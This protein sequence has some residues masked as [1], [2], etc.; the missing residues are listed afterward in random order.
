MIAFLDKLF[1]GFFVVIGLCLVKTF[2]WEMLQCKHRR[3]IQMKLCRE[4]LIFWDDFHFLS[5]EP[6]D[7]TIN[8]KKREKI[9]QKAVR[10][11]LKFHGRW[12][13]RIYFLLWC[14]SYEKNEANRNI[15]L[16]QPWTWNTHGES[17]ILILDFHESF[18]A[19]LRCEKFHK[20]KLSLNFDYWLYR[21]KLNNYLINNFFSSCG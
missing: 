8:N 15:I 16:N 21:V 19:T 5:A 13:R 4:L 6:I 1:Y 11:E 18:A 9:G 10:E 3:N 17:A 2:S 7:E 20:F 14:V 12:W